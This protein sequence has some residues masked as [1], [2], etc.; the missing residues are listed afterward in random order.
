M[1]PDNVYRNLCTGG[2]Q[3]LQRNP[4]TGDLTCPTN[5]EAVKLH[6]GTIVQV[7]NH[8]P[9]Q[10]K[11]VIAPGT[12]WEFG[13]SVRLFITLNI[14]KHTMKPTGVQLARVLRSLEILA[15]YLEGCIRQSIAI[16]SLTRMAV[17]VSSYH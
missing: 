13:R 3:A 8:V 16:L 11:S 14:A 9:H 4:R 6:S 15:I 12:P 5:Y 17:L 7:T 10:V 1:D 2:P